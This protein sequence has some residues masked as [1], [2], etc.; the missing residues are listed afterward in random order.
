MYYSLAEAKGQVKTQVLLEGRPVEC[1]QGGHASF[2]VTPL[3]IAV[4]EHRF[5][6]GVAATVTATRIQRRVACA[7]ELNT[8]VIGSRFVDHFLVDWEGRENVYDMVSGFV[9]AI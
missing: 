6:G 1:L 4:H 7:L 9:L 5:Q 2:A 8:K 3:I